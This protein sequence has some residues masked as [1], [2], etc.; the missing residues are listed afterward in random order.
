M[1]RMTKVAGAEAVTRLLECLRATYPDAH[2]ELV[3]S[4]PLQLLV[5]TILSAQCTDKKVNQVTPA[6]FRKYPT[7]A[8]YASAETAALE[9]E[10]HSLGFFRSKTR[11]LQSCCR[12]LVVRHGGEV[13]RTMAELTA[14]AGVGR[15]TA[16]V[17]LGN[18]FALNEG[19]VVDT[20]VTRLAARLGLSRQRSPEHIEQDL[21][22]LVPRARWTMLSHWL[23]WHGRRRCFARNPDCAGCELASLCPTAG[24]WAKPASRARPSHSRAARDRTLPAHPPEP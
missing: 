22:Q 16:N 17:V 9:Q 12:L 13:P 20:H 2:C 4:T 3:H 5:A 10:L 19:I 11:S 1:A 24:Q 18:A 21:M 14:L 23:I 8:A 15:K 7:A 6:L